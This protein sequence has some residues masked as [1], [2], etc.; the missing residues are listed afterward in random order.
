[1][2][3]R[4]SAVAGA[5]AV[6]AD[7]AV[8]GAGVLTGGAVRGSGSVLTGVPLVVQ[9]PVRWAL[10]PELAQEPCAWAQG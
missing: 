1:M 5:V 2:G 3:T 4:V 9:V 10:E 6:N 8:L 7:V